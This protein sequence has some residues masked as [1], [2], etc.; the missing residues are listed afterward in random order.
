M[1]LKGN[2]INFFSILRCY[3]GQLFGLRRP[4][5]ARR[6]LIEDP[7][8]RLLKLTNE[9]LISSVPSLT[10]ENLCRNA[11]LFVLSRLLSSLWV[12]RT[13]SASGWCALQEALYKCINTIQ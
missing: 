10:H 6:L 8:N 11:T 2:V 4:D 9:L 3:A 13:G 1:D 7:C 12:F 5:S